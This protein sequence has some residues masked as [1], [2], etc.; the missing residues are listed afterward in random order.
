MLQ[1]KGKAVG[2]LSG[3]LDSAIAAKLVIDQ[4]FQVTGIFFDTGFLTKE[5]DNNGK[6]REQFQLL[7]DQLE[8]QSIVVDVFEEYRKVLFAP[9]Y[10]Y[11]KNMNPCIDCKSFFL[12]K[13]LQYAKKINADFIFSGEVL[14]Q[15]PMSQ[16]A[17]TLNII[18]NEAGVKGLLVRPL[19]ATYFQPT[20]VEVSGKLDRSK[21]LSIKGRDRKIQLKLADMWNLNEFT[22]PAGGCLL[23]DPRFSDR[24]REWKNQKDFTKKHLNLLKSGRH[25]KLPD[26]S[27][28]VVG[29][30]EKDNNSLEKI[31]SGNEWLV[32]LADDNVPGA[33]GLYFPVENNFFNEVAQIIGRYSDYKN[34]EVCTIIFKKGNNI[35][36]I[37]VNVDKNSKFSKMLI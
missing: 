2:I 18:E 21:L 5:T 12:K 26:G 11:G 31:Y 30:D 23:T 32:G 4:G 24:L 29:R 16:N 6:S 33:T 14:N 25:F 22:A 34:G 28:L 17:R 1:Y 10:G 8:F 9:K 3:G 36:K 15:R 19:S 35:K 7:A 20:Q 37:D 13:A 27:K